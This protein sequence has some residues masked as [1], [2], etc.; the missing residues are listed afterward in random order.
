MGK[1]RK[2]G[3]D[4]SNRT[5]QTSRRNQKL[6]QH[7]QEL[8]DQLEKANLKD[9]DED[10]SESGSGSSSEE[11]EEVEIP[12]PVAMWDMLHCDPKRCSGKKMSRLGLIKELKLGQKWPGICLSPEGKGVVSPEDK[13]ILKKQGAAVIDCSWE[14]ID[15][16]PFKK[17]KSRHPRLLPWLVAAN[18]VN[19]GK[20]CK[21]NCV[22]ALSA[23]FYICGYPE[24]AAEYMS[25]FSW[26]P[27]F[28]D[29]N[30]ELLDKY[31]ECKTS[32]EVI[33]IQNEHLET[34]ENEKKV[35]ESSKSKQGGGF[36]D[37]VDLPPSQSESETESDSEIEHLVVK[38]DEKS[39]QVGGYLDDLDLPP[40]ESEDESES[41][42]NSDNEDE[43]D[44]Q[45]DSDSGEESETQEEQTDVK[46]KE[47]KVKESSKS[48][49]SGV[50]Y[51]D[52]MDLPPSDIEDDSESQ[53]EPP[54][55]KEKA[56]KVK[57]PSKSNT[58]GGYLDGMDL[59]PSDS[60]SEY[61]S[62]S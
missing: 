25:R 48:K 5:S 36:L 43:D 30:R 23:A 56:K 31:S 16:T 33:K 49:K 21:L 45:E 28:I 35:K 9:E 39:N 34:M 47:K 57:E 8:W 40:S 2:K 42:N 7:K 29:I 55:V 15:E 19:Y 46:G 60:D 10:S 38:K 41:Q 12:F 53:D 52:G 24:V 54:N 62:E 13:P 59:P 3:G 1:P 32:E 50:G 58:S 4:S 22:E 37:G 20:P 18:P 61:E 44:S 11:E 17:M 27:A 26:G 6:Q 14:R 51:L